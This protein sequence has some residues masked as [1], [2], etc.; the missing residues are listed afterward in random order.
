MSTEILPV[1]PA[2]PDPGPVAPP[3]RRRGAIIAAI[4]V[5]G[6]LVLGIVALLVAEAIAKDYARDYVRDRMVA[7]LG[8][9][10]DAEVTVDLGSGSIILQALAGRVDAVEVTA[11]EVAF[12]E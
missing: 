3:R 2:R 9:S 8:L 10:A 11:P 12:G 5:A 7:V 1:E 4:V 6:V